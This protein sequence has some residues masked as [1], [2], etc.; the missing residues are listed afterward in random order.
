MWSLRGVCSGEASSNRG[1]S[2]SPA[3]LFFGGYG[4]EG[5][6]EPGPDGTSRSARAFATAMAVHFHKV[7]DTR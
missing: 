7:Y 6:L 2:W 3:F 5:G 4:G 1:R